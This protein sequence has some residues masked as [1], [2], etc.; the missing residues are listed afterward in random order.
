LGGAQ[1]LAAVAGQVAGDTIRY[2]GALGTGHAD[3]A[4]RATAEGLVLRLTLKDATA[5][6]SA[7]LHLTAD[8]NASVGA[9]GGAL[10]VRR[11]IST[12]GSTGCTPVSQPEY[13]LEAPV[14]RDA[15]G[16][17]LPAAANPAT[18]SLVSSTAGSAQVQVAV[19][20]VWLRAASRAFPVT[21]DV[22]VA[23]AHSVIQ[24]GVFGSVASCAPNMPAP[25]ADMVVGTANGCTYHGLMFFDMAAPVLQRPILSATLHLYALGQSGAVTVRVY[26][27]T[28]PARQTFPAL[29]AATSAP[30]AP[31]TW[32]TGSAAVP[33]PPQPPDYANIPPAQ[34]ARFFV[35]PRPAYQP[36]S[37]STAP[38]IVAGAQG[39][40]ALRFL[41]GRGREQSNGGALPGPDVRAVG[42]R[43]GP[44]GG[45][46]G[47]ARTGAAAL[48][49][50]ELAAHQRRAIGR[51]LPAGWFVRLQ[52]AC[53]R[54]RQ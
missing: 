3:V 4:A 8:A 43:A 46:G 54:H 27:G 5:G 25:F 21:V 41:G 15:S 44:S 26:P 49:G 7:L 14:V 53:L 45:T 10:V 31:G 40:G 32:P 38:G 52:R 39:T 13:V 42:R 20:P 22:P 48:Q 12:C 51:R 1:P 2:P 33:I 9:E 24:P 36:P 17:A 16:N 6:P 35:P 30:P 34:P 23:T 28:P 47:D 50:F 19:D 11:P 18:L 29:P 37:W